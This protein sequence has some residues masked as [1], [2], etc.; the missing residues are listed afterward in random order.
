MDLWQQ[1][2]T[3]IY[4][5]T[6]IQQKLERDWTIAPTSQ[7]PFNDA[8]LACTHG[9]GTSMVFISL[10]REEGA[11]PLN[12]HASSC[13]VPVDDT[14]VTFRSHPLAARRDTTRRSESV[15]AYRTWQ[16]Q[17]FLSN[18]SNPLCLKIARCFLST[19]P[20][21]C[22]LVLGQDTFSCWEVHSRTTASL[23]LVIG[24]LLKEVQNT[25]P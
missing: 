11:K 20:K 2:E 23:V 16:E 7:L 4:T 1:P 9:K 3:T 12:L 10:P 6:R 24:T 8:V 25:G 5:Q 17:V 19:K 22:K 13:N 21:A 14:L 18:T 15:D